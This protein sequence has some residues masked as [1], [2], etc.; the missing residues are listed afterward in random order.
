VSDQLVQLDEVGVPQRGD[1]AELA[2][3][4]ERGV[5]VRDA[6]ELDRD[7]H[8]AAQIAAEIDH[9]HP[10]ASELADDVIAVANEPSE[11]T[12]EHVARTLSCARCLTRSSGSS[13]RTART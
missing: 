1:R 13:I 9:T 12:L 4:P 6:A 7:V 11:S 5:V 10:S 3:E 2:L 8:V